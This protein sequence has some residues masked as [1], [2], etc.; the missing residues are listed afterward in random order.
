MLSDGSLG[1]DPSTTATIV[2]KVTVLDINDNTPT[3]DKQTY[4]ATVQE[5]IVPASNVPDL[6]MTITDIDSV[7]IMFSCVNTMRWFMAHCHQ[8]TLV[9]RFDCILIKAMTSRLPSYVRN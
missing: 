4:T 5:N 6:Q 3:F 7:R 9:G 8:A 2:I 1:N